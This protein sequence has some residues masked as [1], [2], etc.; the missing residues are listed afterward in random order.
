MSVSSSSAHSISAV[1]SY[2]PMPHDWLS[3]VDV[4]TESSTLEDYTVIPTFRWMTPEEEECYHAVSH[5]RVSTPSPEK[6]LHTFTVPLMTDRPPLET[7]RVINFGVLNEIGL[8]EAVPLASCLR[9]TKTMIHEPLHPVFSDLASDGLFVFNLKWYGHGFNYLCSI[10]LSS[11]DG[12]QMVKSHLA[13]LIAIAYCE[14]FQT[15][16]RFELESEGTLPYDSI[17][18]N[19]AMRLSRGGIAFKNIK[20]MDIR[21][22]AK[23]GIWYPSIELELPWDDALRSD[24]LKQSLP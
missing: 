18:D 16:R 23:T 1:P 10:P 17:F 12:R 20:L 13:F 7:S 22:D 24:Q 3:N 21:M 14:L 2:T 11:P 9:G 19:D 15:V 6:Y 5:T 8:R 4:A